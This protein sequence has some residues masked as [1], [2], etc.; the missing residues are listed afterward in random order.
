MTLRHFIRSNRLLIPAAVV[1]LAASAGLQAQSI[2]TEQRVRN[3]QR[4]LERLPHYGVFDFLAFSIDRGAVTLTGSVYEPVLKSDAERAVKRVA[5]VDEVANRIEILPQSMNDDRI[6]RDTFYNIYTDAFL[7]RYSSGGAHA[8]AQEA[9]EFGRILGR[10]PF[11][12]YP[13]RIIVDG[14]RTTLMGVVD[15]AS[16]RQLAEFRAREVP[17]VFGVKN[18]LEIANDSK[19]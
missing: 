8:A 4:A 18:E 11:G 5:G 9:A 19:K 15:N 10:Q 3:V 6:R 7:S 16:D 14:G 13:I 1:A 17:G 2:G 12:Y